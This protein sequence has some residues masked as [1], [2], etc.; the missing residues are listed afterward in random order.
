MELNLITLLICNLC[1]IQVIT[2][3]FR[4]KIVVNSY[5]TITEIK[6][7]IKC[8]VRTE[9]YTCYSTPD[10]INV[11]S[12]CVNLSDSVCN[13]SFNL[14]LNI[15]SIDLLVN[16]SLQFCSEFLVKLCS[17]S[18][19]DCLDSILTWDC[20]SNLRDFSIG[21][22]LSLIVSLLSS[23]CLSSG[24]YLI[25]ILVSSCSSSSLSSA[26]S[27]V[28]LSLCYSC[29]SCSGSLVGS[30]LSSS[31]SILSSSNFCLQSRLQ[32]FN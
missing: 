24:S 20:S 18:G 9:L 10:S 15:D 16:P 19:S 30:C 13:S 4:S 5:F 3:V 11:S 14:T 25:S 28:E 21:V 29:V 22:S 17:S 27:I 6:N 32:S 8:I 1:Y 2:L 26:D 23:S 7:I 31:S 12:S